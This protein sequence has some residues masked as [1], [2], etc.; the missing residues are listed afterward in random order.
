MLTMIVAMATVAASPFGPPPPLEQSLEMPPPITNPDWAVKPSGEDVARYYPERAQ[1]LELEGR[2]TVLCQVK[3][4]GRL[5]ACEVVEESPKDAGFGEATRLLAEHEFQMTPRLERGV[6]VAGSVRI[7]LIYKLPTR[8]EAEKQAERREREF[9]AAI[10][11]HK[12]T[13]TALGWLSL[14]LPLALVVLLVLAGRRRP[15]DV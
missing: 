8:T 12:A 3:V 1:R 2:A 14:L 11:G 10:A 6:P 5:H 13:F 9:V 15:T 4:D 7:P